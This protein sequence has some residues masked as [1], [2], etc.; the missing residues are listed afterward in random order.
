MKALAVIEFGQAKRSIR[1]LVRT[2][3]ITKARAPAYV[4]DFVKK[5]GMKGYYKELLQIA[6]KEIEIIESEKLGE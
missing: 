4:T 1:D 5:Y 3:G 2:Y 6:L